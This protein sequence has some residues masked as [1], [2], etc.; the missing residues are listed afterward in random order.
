M[1]FK[2]GKGS[3]IHMGC[4]FYS[5]KFFSL[6]ENST[7][8]Q[9]CLLDNRAGLYIGSNVSISTHV[10]IFTADHDINTPDF[11]GRTAP[12]IIAM[13]LKGCTIS[14]GAVLGAKSLL[15]KNINE[16][17]IYAG[18]PAKAI[19]IR[20]IEYNYHTSYKRWFH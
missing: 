12:V 11:A 15:T 8:N 7:I 6:G 16:K 3:S 19:G 4:K 9:Y 13:I 18:I 20:N 2:I 14:K 10:K 1:S 17:E 5:R